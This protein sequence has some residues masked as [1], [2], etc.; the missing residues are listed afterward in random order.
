MKQIAL[1]VLVVLTAAARADLTIVQNVDTG[2]GKT[3][4]MTMKIKGDQMRVDPAPEMSIISNGQ[5][6][7]TVTLIHNEKKAMRISGEKLKAAA[8]MVK[9]FASNSPA[10]EQS[11]L[12][13][14]GR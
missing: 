3:T 10:P 7:E 4:Q 11:K 9:K 8:D 13:A 1:L 14:T 12:T 5:T 6:G 2:G